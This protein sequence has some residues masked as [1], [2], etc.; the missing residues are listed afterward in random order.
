MRAA[1]FAIVYIV[2]CGH[3]VFI[4][5]VVSCLVVSCALQE[6]AVVD[7]A[8][9]AVDRELKARPVPPPRVTGRM[10]PVNDRKTAIGCCEVWS[11]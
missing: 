3:A 10:W 6:Q 11:R 4:F 1:M 9:A 2:Y 5:S 8:N 7:G